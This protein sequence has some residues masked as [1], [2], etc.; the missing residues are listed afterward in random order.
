MRHIALTLI[1][2]LLSFGSTQ[3]ICTA[4]CETCSGSGYCQVCDGSGSVSGGPCFICEG[5]TSCYVC[6][7]SGQ[8]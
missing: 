7:G 4:N 3:A 1:F 5:S 6:E 8:F 2:L